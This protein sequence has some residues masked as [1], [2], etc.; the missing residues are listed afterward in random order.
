[1]SGVDFYLDSFLLWYKFIEN[2][3]TNKLRNFDLQKENKILMIIFFLCV[4]YIAS[5]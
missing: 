3:V 2:L 1:M 4:S 5:S